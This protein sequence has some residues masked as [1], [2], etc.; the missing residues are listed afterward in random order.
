VQ[1]RSRVSTSKGGS[2][3]K[4]LHRDAAA[5]ARGPEKALAVRRR[6]TQRPAVA[7]AAGGRSV[8]AAHTRDLQDGSGCDDPLPSTSP[9]RH[10]RA[11]AVERAL[12]EQLQQEQQW[13][14]VGTSKG[15]RPCLPESYPTNRE[16]RLAQLAQPRT[17]KKEK[18]EQV[19]SDSRV[20]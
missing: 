15:H 13:Q 10:S 11:A 1:Q 5:A 6:P 12:A 18:Y 8:P 14:P 4:V 20:G 19:R 3:S 7:A 17:L 9:N 2:S 16:Q